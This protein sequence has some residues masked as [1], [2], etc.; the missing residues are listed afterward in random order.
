MNF[1]LY[2]IHNVRFCRISYSD[3]FILLSGSNS[4]NS[5]PEIPS[6]KCMLNGKPPKPVTKRKNV[7][8][9]LEEMPCVSTTGVGPN[10]KTITGFLYRYSKLEV[11]ILCICHGQSFS[12][13][14]FVKHAGG[15]EVSHPLRHI[16][17][18]LPSTIT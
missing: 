11:S 10:G 18:Q 13:V 6:S 16:T 17:L 5:K 8:T 9:R 1:L 15:G 12:P 7:P 3:F 4:C 2:P 14:E